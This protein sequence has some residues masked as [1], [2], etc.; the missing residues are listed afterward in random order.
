MTFE[1]RIRLRTLM[2]YS[3]YMC[4]DASSS[5]KHSIVTSVNSY[6]FLRQSRFLI[7]QSICNF[8]QDTLTRRSTP[9]TL[10]LNRKRWR[11]P[12]G[13]T[14]QKQTEKFQKNIYTIF[15]QETNNKNPTLLTE[16]FWKHLSVERS[17]HEN[18]LEIWSSWQQVFEDDHEKVWLQVSLM[19]L[20]NNDVCSSP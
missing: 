17:R 9:L 16:V 2:Q 14:K 4:F 5:L 19:N 18:H 6:R 7:W 11:N 20:I 12:E 15:T 13:K 1:S 3:K 10:M 8:T